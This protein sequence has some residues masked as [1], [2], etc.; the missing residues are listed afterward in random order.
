MENRLTIFINYCSNEQAFIRPLLGQALKITNSVIVSIGSHKYRTY[1]P[2]DSNHI[3]T[4][5]AEF[6]GVEFVIYDVSPELEKA[7]P[8]KH[9]PAAYWHNVGRMAAWRKYQSAARQMAD[10]I[11][12]IDADEVPEATVFVDWFRVQILYE[13]VAYRFANYWYFRE[14]TLQATTLE[15]SPIMVHSSRFHGAGENAL[16]RDMERHGITENMPEVVITA[17]MF[18][19]FSWVR[20]EADMIRKVTSWGHCAD[21]ADWVAKVREEF[22]RPFSGT[23]FVHGYTYKS[24]PNIFGIT[25]R[26]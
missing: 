25:L 6:S 8:L 17:P 2:E 15:H 12:F 16:M 11:L 3:S 4:L 26:D 20:T 23:D 18:H 14:P 22:S 24:V 13:D 1:E 10:W 9:R 19:H 5:A 21:R 7:N